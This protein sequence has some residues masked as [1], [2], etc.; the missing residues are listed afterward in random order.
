[1]ASRSPS[2]FRR[3]AGHAHSHYDLKSLPLVGLTADYGEALTGDCACPSMSIVPLHRATH[4]S[5]PAR[6]HEYSVIVR[7]WVFGNV[8]YRAVQAVLPMQLLTIFTLYCY[9]DQ[10]L[11]KIYIF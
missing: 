10:N 9:T 4:F 11:A 2:A 8:P 5:G 6:H 3:H 1:M 7:Q